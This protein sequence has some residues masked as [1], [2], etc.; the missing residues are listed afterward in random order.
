MV[1]ATLVI[2]DEHRCSNV[3]GIH[4]GQYPLYH[5]PLSCL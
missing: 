2:V 4:K 3:H 1:Q 5:I